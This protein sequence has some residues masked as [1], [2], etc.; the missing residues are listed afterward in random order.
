[1]LGIGVCGF[2]EKTVFEILLCKQYCDPIEYA[3]NAG[4]VYEIM[5][6][7]ATV[8]EIEEVIEDEE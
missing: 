8:E 1:M 5:E 4:T 7:G 3:K 6:Y 2:M